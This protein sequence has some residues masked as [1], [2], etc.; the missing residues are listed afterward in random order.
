VNPHAPLLL[1]EHSLAV[2][3]IKHVSVTVS[4]YFELP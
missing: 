3:D 1:L 4:K 2:N